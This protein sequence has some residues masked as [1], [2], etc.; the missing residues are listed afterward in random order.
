MGRLDAEARMMIK[1]L[2][3][4]GAIKSEIARLLGVAHRRYSVDYVA[5]EDA[6]LR[7]RINIWSG[8][9]DMPWDWRTQRR[10]D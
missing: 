1:T 8:A 6:A 10:N 4:G 3:S 7:N 2:S 5:T 9:L